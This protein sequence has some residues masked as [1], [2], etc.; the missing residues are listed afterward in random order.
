MKGERGGWS[1]IARMMCWVLLIA[2][3]MAVAIGVGRSSIPLLIALIVILTLSLIGGAIMYAIQRRGVNRW[4]ML[5]AMEL[6]TRH[7][8]PIAPGLAAFATLCGGGMRRRA[9]MLAYLLDNGT[10]L[11]RALRR[12][13]GLL[14]APTM[15]LV[16]VGSEQGDTAEALRQA[17]AAAESQKSQ[18]SRLAPRLMYLACIMLAACFLLGFCLYFILPKYEAIFADFGMDLPASTT[19]VIVASHMAVDYG[20][21]LLIG[22]VLAVLICWL[23][24]LAGMWD[25]PIVSRLLA[26]RDRAS[27]LR[28]LSVGAAAGRPF[29]QVIAAFESTYPRAWMRKRLARASRLLS[30]GETWTRALRAVRLVTA[31]DVALLESAQA[32]GNLPWALEVLAGSLERRLAYRID[33]ACQVAYPIAIGLCGVAV[34]LWSTAFFLPLVDLIQ[35]LA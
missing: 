33:L 8:M 9:A 21:A 35:K 16:A 4:A 12:V 14:P 19:F 25:P 27:V 2:I 10:P 30:A 1:T 28:G 26:S 17:E 7:G 18:W 3:G 29:E 5:T 6:A 23:G 32:A 13:P 20:L 31:A 22:L 34:L 15:A 11:G 24:V